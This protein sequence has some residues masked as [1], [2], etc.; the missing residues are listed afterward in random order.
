MMFDRM[1]EDGSMPKPRKITGVRIGW[2]VRELDA[3]IDNLPHRDGDH[4]PSND[5]WDDAPQAAA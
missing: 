5:G 4:D 1:V 3:A 2:D